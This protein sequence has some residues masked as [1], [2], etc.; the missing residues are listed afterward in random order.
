M[1]AKTGRSELTRA[2]IIDTALLMAAAEGL[3]SL[4]I[5]EVAKRLGM[6]KSG[7]FSRV[8]SREALQAA[9]IEEYDRRFLQDVFVPA[10]REPRG[11]PRLNAIVRLWLRR[12]DAVES[13]LGCIYCAGAFEFDDRDGPLRDLLL[14]GVM[15]W[16]ATLRRTVLQAVEQGHLRPETDVDQLVFEID[17]LF[18]ALMRDARF[19]RDPR[20]AERAWKAYERLIRGCL[21]TPADAALPRD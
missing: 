3:E 20:A 8:G 21:A 15:R 9:V 17:G 7:V 5:G 14:D 6:S 18:I 2:A 11:L 16:R 1:E 10:M 19:L 12:V 13:R 4:T